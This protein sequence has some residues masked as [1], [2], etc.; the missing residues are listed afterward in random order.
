MGAKNAV[1]AGD[2]QK[3]IVLNTGKC[4]AIATG[5]LKRVELT[6][7]TVEAYEVV[8]ES[9]Q[10]SAVSAVGRG[11]AGS[12]LLGPV[13]MLAGLSAKKKGTHTVAVQFKDGSKSLLEIDDKM[14]KK[15]M[16]DLF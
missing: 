9:S 1:I 13:G 4:I 2:Y 3:K 8:D 5:F 12:L 14:Y 10:T 15:L 16:T 6:K 11:L 7:D